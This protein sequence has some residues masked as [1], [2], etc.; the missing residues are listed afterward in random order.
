MTST[1]G[2]TLICEIVVPP[3]CGEASKAIRTSSLLALVPIVQ[4]V[5]KTEFNRKGRKGRKKRREI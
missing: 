4:N 1:R 2:V 3:P 5:G